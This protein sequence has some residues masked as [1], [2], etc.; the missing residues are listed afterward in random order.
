MSRSDGEGKI[1]AVLATSLGVLG[2]L[3]LL[4]LQIGL[5]QFVTTINSNR[6]YEVYDQTAIFNILK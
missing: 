4:T 6:T 3:F 1:E 5:I 2:R